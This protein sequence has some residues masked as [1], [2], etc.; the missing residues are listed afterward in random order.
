MED[1]K[2]KNNQIQTILDE[3]QKIELE[4]L[5][6]LDQIQSIK[7]V[8]DKEMTSK[9]NKINK[10]IDFVNVKESELNFQK[11]TNVRTN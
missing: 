11:Q 7:D 2:S 6:L 5:S 3:K 10:L 8:Y 1:L 9:K 4:K